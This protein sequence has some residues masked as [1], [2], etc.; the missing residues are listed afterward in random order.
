MPATHHSSSTMKPTQWKEGLIGIENYDAE[1]QMWHGIEFPTKATGFAFKSLRVDGIASKRSHHPDFVSAIT[2]AA[3]TLTRIFRRDKQ[4]IPV[5][6]GFDGMVTNGQTLLVLGRPGSGCSTLLKVI[7]GSTR[8]LKIGDETVLSYQGIQPNKMHTQ[9]RSDCIY[10]A[11]S[12]VHFP[13]LT[14][15]ETLLVAAEAR[16]PANLQT[17][18]AR[19]QY[20]YAL[21]QATIEAFDLTA[22]AK[23]KIGN[24]VI[25]GVS[26]G[27]RR[28]VTLAE[29]FMG[30]AAVQCWDQSTRGM[31]SSTALRFIRTLSSHVQ[32]RKTAAA[33]SIYQCSQAMYNIFDKVIVLYQGRQIYFGSATDAEAY[34]INM[35]FDRPPTSIS[36]ADFLTALTHP[37]EASLM[38]RPGY[39]HKVPRTVD[40]FVKTWQSS[41]QHQQLLSA[42]GDYESKNPVGSCSSKKHMRLLTELRCGQRVSNEFSKSPWSLSCSAQL[43]LCVRRA[44][45]RLRNQIQVPISNIVANGVLALIVGSIFYDL[46]ET[47]KSFYGRSVLIFFA[48]MLNGFMSGFE[49]LTIWAQRPIVEKQSRLG[50]YQPVAEVISAMICDL[51]NKALSSIFFNVTLYFMANLR[52][53]PQSFFTFLLFSLVCLLTMSMFFRSIG[54]LCRTFSQTFIPVGTIMFMCI[55]YTGFVIPPKYIRPWFGWFRHIN[56]LA[57]A[58][59]SLMINEFAGRDFACGLFVPSGPGYGPG[60]SSYQACAVVGAIPGNIAVDGSSYLSL[61]YGYSGAHKWRNLG[62]LFCMMGVMCTIH[63]VA[64]QY[65]QAE[66]P[67]GEVP[68]FRRGCKNASSGVDEESALS[69]TQPANSPFLHMPRGLQKQ[70]AILQW[71]KITYEVSSKHRKGHILKD[72]SGWARPGT[73]TALMGATGAGKTTLLNVLAGRITSGNLTGSIYVDGAPKKRDFARKLGYSQQEDIHLSTATVRE[74][75]E[76]SAK[77]RQPSYVPEKEKVRYVDEIIDVMGLVDCADAIVG[78]TGEGLN[79]EQRR[80]LTIAIEMVAKPEI[81]FL[82]EP[83]SGLDS[84][85]AWSICSL[86]RTLAN[87]DQ[88]IICTIH[89]P[90]AALLEMFDHLLLID[91]GKTVYFGPVGT[92]CD[93]IVTYFQKYG[94]HPYGQSENP[95][96]WM[97]ETI[98]SS[99]E[100][101]WPA[102]WISSSEQAHLLQE[103]SECKKL[104]GHVSIGAPERSDTYAMPFLVQVRLLTWRTIVDCWRIPTYLWGK[105][106]FYVL[107]SMI[108]GFSFWNAPKSLQGLQNQL[109]AVFLVVST[110]SCAM[111]QVVPE[112]IRRREL[113]EAREK[114][115]RIYSWQA[116]LISTTLT[117][118]LWQTAIAVLAFPLWYYPTG[119][120]RNASGY[121]RHERGTLVFL[122]TWSFFVFTSTLSYVLA[123]TM[124]FVETAVN[125]AQLLFYLCLIFCGVLAP[126]SSMPRFWT[127]MYRV[128]P[129][130]YQISAMFSA[131]VAGTEIVC[132]DEEL[133]RFAPFPGQTCGEYMSSFIAVAGGRVTKPDSR[134]QCLFCPL[135]GTDDFLATLDIYYEDRWWQ[136]ATQMVYI[137]CNVLCMGGLYWAIRVRRR[138]ITT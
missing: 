99:S 71:S 112:F 9:F 81:L 42:I 135:R 124:E 23:T 58:F 63:L 126:Q 129:L 76:F 64:G 32:K 72:I 18:Q 16:T 122:L 12:D 88:T 34:F 8:G 91:A 120:F 83:T 49:V 50:F 87:S 69:K 65:I 4:R 125:I 114:A 5:L 107:V 116:F 31:D 137:V 77:L 45:K 48:T 95:S 20:S 39:E 1:S 105:L 86:L 92:Q 74:A 56:P 2:D 7:G 123:A 133:I 100:I 24:Q 138:S 98:S 19:R 119:M 53:T 130:T 108:I 128:S 73:L 93:S 62:I 118:I 59:E 25:R 46:D 27:E 131:A 110:F 43:G 134:A 35:G 127:F 117:E 121:Q 75:L 11:E 79:V 68:S 29:A 115:S 10:T 57:Y 28:R 52:R 55:I 66:L 33:V 67:R 90:S 101:D 51:P 70:T 36:T 15:E 60:P 94:A 103:L 22:C 38:I 21:A 37:P 44:L 14:V 82:D 113:F 97:C 6:E 84:Q 106:M 104:Q 109:F 26:G 80:K 40:D 136:F 30:N 61:T 54:S 85:T 17:S 13:E 41:L 78:V 132:A 96:E 89:Q 102:V 3:T 47:S 111:Q